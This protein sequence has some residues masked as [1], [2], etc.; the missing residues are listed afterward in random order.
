MFIFKLL[1]GVQMKEIK[2]E[3]LSEKE[4]E[5]L[6]SASEA[7]NNSYSPYSKFS[8]G[9]AI[10]TQDG[11]IITGA[12]V[13]NAAYGSSICA[14]RSAIMRAN[15]M[16]KRMFDKI[17]IISKGEDFDTKEPSAPCGSC[18]QVIFEFAQISKKDI[19]IIL[20]NTKMSK[21]IIS[22]ISEILPMAFGPDDL[23]INV[24]KYRR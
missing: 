4:K 15:A 21:I 9:A 8:V 3:E 17:A 23:G 13:E 19:E 24:E 10:L 7:M 16:G 11:Q 2:F 5:L 14:E 1:G 6:K 12:N 18:R 22:T 20:S